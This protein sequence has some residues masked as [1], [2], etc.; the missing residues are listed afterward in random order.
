M[1]L[2][3]LFSDHLIAWILSVTVDPAGMTVCTGGIQYRLS[4]AQLDQAACTVPRGACT[5]P[6]GRNRVDDRS[7]DRGTCRQFPLRGG[8]RG[9]RRWLRSGRGRRRLGLGLGRS[10]RSCRPPLSRVG[11]PP[12]ACCR[13]GPAHRTGWR[14]YRP[15]QAA[16]R[17]RRC[18]RRQR[19]S[20]RPCHRPGAG[21]S[22]LMDQ[23]WCCLT[24]NLLVVLAGNRDSPEILHSHARVT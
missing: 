2:S 10:A 5:V 15:A 21:L 18:Q 13:P 6:R 20:A 3:F 11:Q 23:K 19:P 17:D 12:P 4:H 16:G 1:P 8:C 7:V 24:L 14:W 22:Q 9:G